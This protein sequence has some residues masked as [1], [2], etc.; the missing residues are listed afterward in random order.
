[1]F[2]IWHSEETNEE[3]EWLIE[4]IR[5]INTIDIQNKIPLIFI[6]C[7]FQSK[8]HNVQSHCLIVKGKIT[9]MYQNSPCHLSNDLFMFLYTARPSISYISYAY[10]TLLAT[11]GCLKQYYLRF[12]CDINSAIS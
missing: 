10:I 3:K 6:G 9:E 11:F 4:I 8:L 1:M 12:Q 5:T 7:K 2:P